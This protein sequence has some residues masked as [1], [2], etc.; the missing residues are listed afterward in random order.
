MK[1]VF[2]IFLV[3]M[4]DILSKWWASSQ[5]PNIALIGNWVKITHIKNTGI[6]FSTPLPG[7][8][9]L[10]PLI[11]CGLLIF[12]IK[13]WKYISEREKL[14]YTLIITWG[15]LNAI[16]RS[17]FWSVT[18]MISIHYFA[19]FNVADIAVT[20]GVLL[21]ILSTALSHK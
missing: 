10:I 21:I 7:I 14:W 20:C 2:I 16:E 9:F 3:T 17:I 6:A 5:I 13:S 12:V 8:H 18:D 1:T 19:V 11:L 15:V 4:S